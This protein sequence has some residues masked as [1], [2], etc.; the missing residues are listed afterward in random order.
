MSR[1]PI[2]ELYLSAIM[3]AQLRFDSSWQTIET[4]VSMKFDYENVYVV[5]SPTAEDDRDYDDY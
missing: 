5:E 4:I 1:L 2:S 3:S